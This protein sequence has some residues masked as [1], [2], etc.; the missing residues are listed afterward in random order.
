MAYSYMQGTGSGLMFSR[1]LGLGHV[2]QECRESSRYVEGW[3]RTSVAITNVA[4]TDAPT[5]SGCGMHF[6]CT[7]VGPPAEARIN[8]CHLTIF[9]ILF[10]K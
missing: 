5:T 3:Q 4:I 6:C 8:H 7:K 2:S 9:E 1:R 10:T